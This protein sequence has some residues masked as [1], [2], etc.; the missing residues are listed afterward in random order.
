MIEWRKTNEIGKT[1]YE[2]KIIS[3]LKIG[4]DKFVLD[5]KQV[6][7]EIDLLYIS[8][9]QA[10]DLTFLTLAQWLNIFAWAG[11]EGF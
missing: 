6:N 7:K 1:R 3:Q 5:F 11:S 10:V 4:Q 8:L 9:C 2:K